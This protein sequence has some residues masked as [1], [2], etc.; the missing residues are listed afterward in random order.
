MVHIRLLEPLRLSE[1]KV[2]VQNDEFSVLWVL[3]GIH[4][5]LG[6]ENGESVEC[7]WETRR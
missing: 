1:E 4:S 5:L 7:E 2:H 6:M 3:L